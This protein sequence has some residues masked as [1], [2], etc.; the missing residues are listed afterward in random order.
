MQIHVSNPKSIYEAEVHRN[1]ESK[2]K[3]A[4]NKS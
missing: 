1:E 4:E 3:L 2:D